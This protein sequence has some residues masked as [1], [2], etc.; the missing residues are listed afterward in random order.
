MFRTQ[1]EFNGHQ[2]PGP[3]GEGGTKVKLVSFSVNPCDEVLRESTVD[4]A[5]Q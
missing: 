5:D 2:W 1:L 4:S 3:M